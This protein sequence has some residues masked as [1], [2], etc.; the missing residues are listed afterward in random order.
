MV[1]SS[2]YVSWLAERWDQV[3]HLHHTM[4][5]GARRHPLDRLP[6]KA[7]VG[8]RTPSWNSPEDSP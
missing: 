6:G 8:A 1:G 4:T 3:E 5:L 7:S 2:L